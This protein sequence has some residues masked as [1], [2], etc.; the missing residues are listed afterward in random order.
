MGLA[1]LL[2][3]FLIPARPL[4][5][6]RRSVLWVVT[7]F[8]TTLT[9]CASVG[10]AGVEKQEGPAPWRV[11]GRVGFTLDAATLPDSSGL[12]LEVAL[13]VPPATILQLTRD[14]DGD[15]KL[16]AQVQV[17]G[18]FGSRGTASERDFAIAASDTALGQGKVLIFRFPAAPGPCEI[19]ARLEDMLSKRKGLLYTG[20]AVNENAQIVGTVEVP[21]PQAGRDLSDLEFL[22]PTHGERVGLAFVRNGRAV[23]PNPERLYGLFAG[24]LHAA[25]IARA[26][27][28]DVRPWHWVARL[29]DALGEGVAQAESATVATQ[30][31]DGD[32]TFDVSSEPAGAYDLE[33][34]AWQEGDA[35]ALLRRSR[36]SIAWKGDTW[37]RNSADVTDEAHF[38]LDG[39]GEDAF[40]VMQPGQQE[41]FLGDFWKVRDPTPETAFNEAYQT[42]RERVDHANTSFHH[43]GIEKG[44]FSDQGRTYIRYGEPTEILHQVIPA[45]DETLTQQLE[46]LSA[47]EDRSAAD[48]RQHGLGGDMRPFEVWVYEGDIALPPDADPRVRDRRPPR[49]RIVFLF[50]DQ[51]GTGNYVLRYSTE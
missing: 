43:I 25:F 8:A 7:A 36:F 3:M 17:R 39:D 32:I 2:Q 34:K 30:L 44:M 18:R 26:K 38:L 10:H 19:Q 28:G 21:K 24:E 20:R 49:R 14:A 51:H 6:A 41:R 42:F 35:G 15:A 13:R 50:V 47:T 46:D 31:L 23:V 9:L 11:G 27:P 29:Y 48:V 5:G 12:Q 16:H 37:L 33:V 1:P 40:A 22:W 4:R 45:G